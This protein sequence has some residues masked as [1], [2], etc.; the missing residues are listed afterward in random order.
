MDENGPKQVQMGQMSRFGGALQPIVDCT[1]RGLVIK[2]S[3]NLG[4][5]RKQMNESANLWSRNFD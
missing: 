1:K 4:I 5:D 2:L 3:M